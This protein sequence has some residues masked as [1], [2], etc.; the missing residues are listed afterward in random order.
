MKIQTLLP[1]LALLAT[2]AVATCAPKADP[3]CKELS[4]FLRSVKPDE[5]R[6]G[7]M[8]TYWGAREVGDQL[9]IGSKSCEH[10][11]YEPGKRFCAYLMEHS[12]TEFAGYNAKRIL[13]CLAPFPSS[14]TR[15]D[16]NSGSFSTQ[17]GSSNPGALVDLDLVR[18]NKQ[19][20]MVLV[21]K[22]DGY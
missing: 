12:S 5:T 17:F 4:A 18:D 6:S 1:A 22:A 15:L 19:E 7:T 13:N 16:I 20:E 10:S 3:L 9:V 8:R 21:L 14:K 2:P 11:D